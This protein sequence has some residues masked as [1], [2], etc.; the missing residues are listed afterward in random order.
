MSC[1]G[2]ASGRAGSGQRVLGPTSP[3]G[4]VGNV[5]LAGDDA[6]VVEEGERTL[7]VKRVPLDGGRPVIALTLRLPADK[8][9]TGQVT[10]SDRVTG[11]VVHTETPTST[12]GDTQVF[13]GPASGRLVALGRLRP[14]RP[15]VFFAGNPQ[16]E[17]DR[18]FVTEYRSD[19]RAT[20]HVLYEHGRPPRPIRLPANLLQTD[21]AGDLVAYPT[22]GTKRLVVRNWRTG[23]RQSVTAVPS[24]VES[25]DL[26]ADGRVLI[27]D[28]DANVSEIRP[29]RGLRQV[30]RSGALARYAGARIAYVQRSQRGPQ[31][32]RVAIIEPEPNGATRVLSAPTRPSIDDLVADDRHVVWVSGGCAFAAAVAAPARPS[33]EDCARQRE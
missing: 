24:E 30:T 29:G 32:D 8:I 33:S 28:D 26:A 27:S 4:G 1:G 12:L 10:A 25:L 17:E 7:R 2:D 31:R 23:R 9:P 3:D 20:R 13:R 14:V 11:L 15:R 22:P 18:L 16:A 19:L 21:F 6:L 5:A